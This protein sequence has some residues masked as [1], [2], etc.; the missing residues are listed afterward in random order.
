MTSFAGHFLGPDTHANRPAVGTLPAGTM[1]VCTTHNKIERIVAGAWV[2]YATLGSTA[3]VAGDTIWDAKGDLAVARGPTRQRSFPPARTTRMPQ[4]TPGKARRQTGKPVRRRRLARSARHHRPLAA[5]RDRTSGI[6]G[7]TQRSGFTPIARGTG[8]A[9]RHRRRVRPDAA[10]TAP[11]PTTRWTC[12]A[13]TPRRPSRRHSS[14]GG[15]R[16]PT[17]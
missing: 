10:T 8:R 9:S 2:D 14:S 3:A 16:P 17:W 7:S 5:R 11:L 4:P 6:S 1:Y 15:A 13:R 12:A